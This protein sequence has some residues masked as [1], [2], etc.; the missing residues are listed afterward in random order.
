MAYFLR[1]GGDYLDDAVKHTTKADAIAAFR[2]T[3]EELDRFGNTPLDGSIHI[4]DSKST[5]DEYPD[6]V[7]SMGP[8]GGVKVE[9]A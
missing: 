5:L 6:F 8:R 7:L 9:R 2:E 3:N 1:M 4:A